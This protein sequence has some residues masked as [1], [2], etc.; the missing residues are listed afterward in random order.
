MDRPRHIRNL[1]LIGFMGTGKSSVGRLLAQRLRFEF[2]DTDALIEE[3]AGQ[4]ISEI[5]A[6]RG[7]AVFREIEQQV[8]A[9][10][11]HRDGVVIAT[12]GGLGANPANLASLQQH[13]L[14]ICLWASAAAVWRRVRRQTHRPL[15]QDPNPQEKIRA[16]LAQREPVYRT[17][18][19]LV[20]TEAR[21]A[22]VVA[23]HI[24]REVRLSC[25]QL[26]ER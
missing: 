20:N 13:A 11:A 5:F 16:L 7:E 23:Q 6:R 10:L 26:L 18:D 9:E 3:R 8:V 14:V 2:V 12:G 21:S 25:P 4:C 1:A 15:L 19:V 17:A 22:R 24:L